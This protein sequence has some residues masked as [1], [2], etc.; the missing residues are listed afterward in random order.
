MLDGNGALGTRIGRCGGHR[1]FISFSLS[2]F[3]MTWN[4][5]GGKGKESHGKKRSKAWAK[6][7]VLVAQSNGE[8]EPA[9][10]K[11][12]PVQ[13]AYRPVASTTTLK[14]SASDQYNC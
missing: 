13:S 11:E 2:R 6:Q 1:V 12:W 3:H 5:C 8:R 10:S 7:K 4:P 14:L 9:V